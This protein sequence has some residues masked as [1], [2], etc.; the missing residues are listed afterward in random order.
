M[1]LAESNVEP[2]QLLEV[3]L[4][5]GALAVVLGVKQEVERDGLALA[6][7]VG[8]LLRALGD[9]RLVLPARAADTAVS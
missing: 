1:I 2:E 4:H 5:V 3:V 7:E 9:R 6:A 8:G